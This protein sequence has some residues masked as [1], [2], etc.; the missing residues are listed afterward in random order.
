MSFS[1]GKK[2]KF[3]NTFTNTKM[4]YNSA[5]NKDLQRK[6]FFYHANFFTR[7]FLL[8]PHVHKRVFIAITR[9]N[10]SALLYEKLTQKI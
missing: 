9:K 2:I 10:N 8:Q 1:H 6:N 3:T 4:L 5:D 7:K